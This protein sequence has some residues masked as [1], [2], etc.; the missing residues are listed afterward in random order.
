MAGLLWLVTARATKSAKKWKTSELDVLSFEHEV[1]FLGCEISTNEKFSA[2]YLRQ[3]PYIE[4]ILRHHGTAETELSPIQSPKEWVTF[5]ACEGE[6]VGAADDVKQAQRA[7]G[8]LL[9]I[10][11]R[12]RRDISFVVSA[13]GSLLTRAAPSCFRIAARLRSYLQRTKHLALSLNPT[14]EDFC[15]VHGQFVCS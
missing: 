4:E 14:T 13:M 11:Q 12:S 2:C 8:E 1:R 6:E 5:E 7:C 15:G 3:R 10:A 9:W